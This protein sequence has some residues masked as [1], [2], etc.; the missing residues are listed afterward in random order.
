MIYRKNR[1]RTFFLKK[2]RYKSVKIGKILAISQQT[3]GK[4][5]VWRGDARGDGGERG[6]ALVNCGGETTHCSSLLERLITTC[7]YQGHPSLRL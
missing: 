7:S 6:G 4:K 1:F 3:P 2:G 5:T